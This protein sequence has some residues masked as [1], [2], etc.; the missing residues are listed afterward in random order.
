M[1]NV[2]LDSVLLVFDYFVRSENA[3]LS[4]IMYKL[5]LSDWSL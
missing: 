4:Q 2:Q 5:L 1:I 3:N